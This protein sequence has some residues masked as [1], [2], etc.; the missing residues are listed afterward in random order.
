MEMAQ[1]IR[2]MRAEIE[3]LQI[4]VNKHE[5]VNENL[6]KIFNNFYNNRYVKEEQ[7]NGTILHSEEFFYGSQ[8]RR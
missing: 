7:D 4:I 8:I 1:E 2:A 3:E 6:S 5:S